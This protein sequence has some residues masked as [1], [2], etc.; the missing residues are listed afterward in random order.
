MEEIKIAIECILFC[1]NILHNLLLFEC[2]EMI[3][4]LVDHLTSR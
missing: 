2:L 1:Q 3:A 4:S